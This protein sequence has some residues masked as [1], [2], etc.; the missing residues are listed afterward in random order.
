VNFKNYRKNLFN[1]YYGVSNHQDCVTCHTG[2]HSIQQPCTTTRAP[3]HPL[4]HQTMLPTG[5]LSL[6]HAFLT[7]QP[8]PNTTWKQLCAQTC[9]PAPCITPQIKVLP[10][11]SALALTLLLQTHTRQRRLLTDPLSLINA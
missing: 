3:N 2:H 4:F 7:L 10:G 1:F 5:F 6:V 8:E 9:L 11:L